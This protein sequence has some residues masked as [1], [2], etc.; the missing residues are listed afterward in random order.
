MSNFSIQEDYIV[1]KP[2]LQTGLLT[3]EISF[4]SNNWVILVKIK[5]I[6]FSLIPSRFL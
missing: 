1:N 5:R 2:V 3:I 6:Y 4:L